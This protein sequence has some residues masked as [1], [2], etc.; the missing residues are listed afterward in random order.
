[1]VPYKAMK[2]DFYNF[3]KKNHLIYFFYK[4]IKGKCLTLE[5]YKIIKKNL[6]R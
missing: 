3:I 4:F 1:M 6:I 2:P 5:V